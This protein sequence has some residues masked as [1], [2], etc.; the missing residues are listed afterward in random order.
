M[1]NENISKSGKKNYRKIYK[2]SIY[3]IEIAIKF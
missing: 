1:K 3:Y 2:K